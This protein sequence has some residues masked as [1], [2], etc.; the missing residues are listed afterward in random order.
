MIPGPRRIAAL[1]LLTA[2]AATGEAA[3]RPTIQ[4][5]LKDSFFPIV[6]SINSYYMYEISPDTL[7]QAGLRGA[8]QAL[9]PSSG[10]SISG[11][12]EDW[13]RNFSTFER[14]VRVVDR[15][16]FYTVGA[17]TLIRYGIHGM[18]SVLDQDTVF[19][20]KL[21]LDNFHINTRFHQLQTD[22]GTEVLKRI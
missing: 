4:D 22:L 13:Q 12:E 3:A 15:K 5:E 7:M 11:P 9:D 16:A 20:E 18:M 14:A 10:F 6:R 21:S 19:M 17:D 8:F 1:V 2:A